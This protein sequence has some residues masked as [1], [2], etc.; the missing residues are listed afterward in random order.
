[1]TKRLTKDITNNEVWN[2]IGSYFEQ[3]HLKQLVRHQVES[4]NRFVDYKIM[5]TIEM[6]NPL[7]IHSE[8]DFDPESNKYKLELE[9]TFSNFNL[10]RPLI[11]LLRL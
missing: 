9:I 2:I 6:F 7:I 3:Q 10:H 11:H 4:F 5:N 8:T 1:M